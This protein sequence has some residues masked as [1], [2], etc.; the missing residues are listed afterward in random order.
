MNRHGHEPS[1]LIPNEN[2]ECRFW[3]KRT[4]E[5]L[6]GALLAGHERPK[7]ILVLISA[8]TPVEAAFRAGF[9]KKTAGV[10]KS[11]PGVM[12]NLVTDADTATT[13]GV[14]EG[15]RSGSSRV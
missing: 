2:P 15:I 6:T 1:N 5:T 3:R 12:A 4:R 9:S 13:R 14:G 7:H 10:S 8:R 11:I